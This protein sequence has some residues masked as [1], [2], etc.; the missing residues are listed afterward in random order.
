MNLPVK[1]AAVVARLAD[2]GKITKTDVVRRGIALEKFIEDVV[3]LKGRV[4]IERSD[5]RVFRV[6]LP[7]LE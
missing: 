2:A 7:W 6:L 5:G 1:D 3:A 4:M